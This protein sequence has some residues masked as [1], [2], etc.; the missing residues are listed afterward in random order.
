[1]LMVPFE[2]LEGWLL[3]RGSIGGWGLAIF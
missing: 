2:G 3:G 1:M